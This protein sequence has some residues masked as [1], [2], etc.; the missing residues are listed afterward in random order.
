[1]RLDCPLTTESTTPSPAKRAKSW[2]RIYLRLPLGRIE[3]AK[4]ASQ[5]PWKKRLHRVVMRRPLSKA[6]RVPSCLFK[7]V[8]IEFLHNTRQHQHQVWPRR[9]E[10]KTANQV[11]NHRIREKV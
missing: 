7:A 2:A 1:M 3:Q 4:L 9:H 11:E 6:S 8:K 10:H 5:Q